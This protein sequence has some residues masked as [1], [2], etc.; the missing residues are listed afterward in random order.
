MRDGAIVTGTVVDEEGDPVAGAEVRVIDLPAQLLQMVPFERFHPEGAL[1]VKEGGTDVV[2][3]MPA[4]VKR[5]FD[6]LP[7]PTA[8]SGAD[9]SFRVTGIEPGTNVLVVTAQDFT[10]HMQPGLQLKAGVEKD[11]GELDLEEGEEVWGKSSTRAASRSRG[12]R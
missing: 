4:W 9:G 5:R 7:I 11:V 12:P 3:R 10:P 6:E 8:R 1:I 2:V